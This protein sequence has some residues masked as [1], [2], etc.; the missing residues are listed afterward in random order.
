MHQVRMRK[1]GPDGPDE[2]EDE[3]AGALQAEWADERV[4]P[5]GDFAGQ[6]AIDQPEEWRSL[7]QPISA[8][9]QQRSGELPEARRRKGQGRRR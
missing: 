6:R 4:R 3:V 8:V 1:E 5:I 7:Q 9:K 2:H